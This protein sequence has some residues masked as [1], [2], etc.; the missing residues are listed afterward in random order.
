MS[1]PIKAEPTKA[2]LLAATP[3]AFDTNTLSFT[4]MRG[5]VSKHLDRDTLIERLA[6]LPQVPT[7]RGSVDLLVARGASGERATPDA[8]MLTVEGGM[9]G[10]R[11]AT[12]EKY[13]PAYQMATT[14]TDVARTIANGQP[15]ALHGDN[16]FLTL[17]LS[18]ANLP[19]GSRL[20]IGDAEVVVTPKAHNGC[21]KWV[22]RFG[23]PAMQ[24]NMAPSH[25]ALRLRGIYLR[26]IEPGWVRVGDVV[27]VLGRG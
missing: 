7:E 22:Q 10:D 6:A 9:P 13:G 20:R 19:V 26:V 24:L 12:E 14:R 3:G 16:L 4:G 15:L 27:E 25:R 11:W 18:A 2:D 1:E 17:N 23:L 8:V 5:D 21:K